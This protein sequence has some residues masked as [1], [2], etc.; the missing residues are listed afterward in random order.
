M[1]VLWNVNTNQFVFMPDYL[2]AVDNGIVHLSSL[3]AIWREM[4]GL[5]YIGE[6]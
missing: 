2:V 5:A 3:V 6:L 1:K 4:P